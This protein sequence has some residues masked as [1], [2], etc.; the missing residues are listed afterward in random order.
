VPV[1][2]LSPVSFQDRDYYREELRKRELEA[3]RARSPVYGL[4]HAYR[5]VYVWL[6]RGPARSQWSS[7]LR[8]VLFWIVAGAAVML[9]VRF[10]LKR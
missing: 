9:A 5:V 4:V 1:E 2:R 7:L 6:V 3:R 8:V 10:F